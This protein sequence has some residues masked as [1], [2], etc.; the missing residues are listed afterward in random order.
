MMKKKRYNVF[1]KGGLMTETQDFYVGF[2]GIN[3]DLKIKNSELLS[4]FVDVAGAHSA[5]IGDG[6]TGEMVR[7]LL[8]GYKVKII[9]RPIHGER[10][11]IT[12]WATEIKGIKSSREFEIRNE[13]GELLVVA[14]SS[15]VSYNLETRKPERVS[16]AVVDAYGIEPNRSNFV[17]CEFEK[18]G[19]NND[20]FYVIGEEVV[21][22]KFIDLNDHLNNSWY[23]DIAEHYLTDTDLCFD[24]ALYSDFEIVFKKEIK[25]GNRILLKV[26][27]QENRVEVLFVNREDLTVHAKI[28]YYKF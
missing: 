22:W 24:P 18:I 19:I 4:Y 17:N 10:I 16:Q 12:T 23:M 13:A 27:T 6:F 20:G 3:K 1:K 11:F 2:R 9:R 8:M 21:D 7:W 5:K 25:E 26:K 15:W 14:L 28:S